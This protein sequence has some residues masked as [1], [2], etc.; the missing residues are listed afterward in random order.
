MLILSPEAHNN[1]MIYQQ[2]VH[3]L[4]DAKAYVADFFAR[5]VDLVNRYFSSSDETTFLSSYPIV[6]EFPN[7]RT[8]EGYEGLGNC[9]AR[10]VLLDFDYVERFIRDDFPTDRPIYEPYR[11]RV[12]EWRPI[13]KERAEKNSSILI[14]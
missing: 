3:T 4:P 6:G 10:A 5:G 13:W 1:V 14:P 7:H 12:K 11:E 9:I 8:T 2:L